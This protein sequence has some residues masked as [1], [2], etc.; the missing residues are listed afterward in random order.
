MSTT[1]EQTFDLARQLPPAEQET[2][3]IYIKRA[4][5]H[6]PI[7]YADAKTLRGLEQALAG[8]GYSEEEALARME[9][10]IA[11]HITR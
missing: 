10:Y 5:E 7:S 6:Q 8:E 3:A 1:L 11:T 2:L 9:A 4:L